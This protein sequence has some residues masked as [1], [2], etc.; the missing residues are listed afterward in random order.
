MFNAYNAKMSFLV[1]VF[2]NIFKEENSVLISV[3]LRCHTTPSL[4][5]A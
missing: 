5:Q 1:N 3:D 2:L 4:G